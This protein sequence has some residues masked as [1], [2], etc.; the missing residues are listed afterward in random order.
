MAEPIRGEIVA[1][2]TEMLLG[3]LIDTNSAFIAQQLKAIG[4]NMYFKHT[5]GDNLDRIAM[6]I[7]T[8]HARSQVVITTGGLG[9]TVDDLTREA[10]AKAMGVELEFR[11]D[12][13]DYIDAY[14]KRRGFKMSENNRKQAFVPKGAA[15]IENPRGTA[16]CFYCQDAKGIILV[17]PGVPTEMRYIIGERAIPILREKFPLTD[18]IRTRVLKSCGLG[19]SRVDEMISD[20]FRESINPSIGVLA[21]P[22]QVDVRITARAASVEEAEK[23]IDGLEAEVRERLGAAIY[24]VGEVTLEAAVAKLLAEKGR[25]LALVETNTGGAILQRL[26]AWPERVKFLKRGVVVLHVGELARMFRLPLDKE[27]AGEDFAEALAVRVREESG[28]DLGLAVFGPNPPENIEP[29][30]SRAA[31]V[32]GDTHIALSTGSRILRHQGNFGGDERFV[33]SRVPVFA[34]DLVRRA[35]LSLG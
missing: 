7:A 26:S 21:H 31:I 22:G 16:P 34:M 13:Y 3:D 8:A 17:S 30:K 5:V 11:Q 6:V 4:V 27:P 14:F 28:A 33:Q 23:M 18:V 9:P 32:V 10:V 29:E 35:L 25:T 24:G 20:L 19:E 12:L 15:V 2:G 1:I